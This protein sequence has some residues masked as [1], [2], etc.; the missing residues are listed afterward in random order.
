MIRLTG[1]KDAY[2]GHPESMGH[3]VLDKEPTETGGGGE[4]IHISVAIVRTDLSDDWNLAFFWNRLCVPV[5][6]PDD[7]QPQP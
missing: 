2:L 7:W 5:T 1:S 4:C 3:V 6:T